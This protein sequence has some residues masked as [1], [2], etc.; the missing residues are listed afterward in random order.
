M[1]SN[2][3]Q[4]AIAVAAV[5]VFAVVLL[6][7]STFFKGLRLDMTE[8]KLFTLSAGSQRI[9]EAIEEPIHLY[10][11]FSEESSRELTQLR[12]YADRVEALL[13][14]YV[15]LSK[16]NL[17]LTQIDPMPFSEAEDQADGFG[18][19]K[20][21]VGS[22]GETLYF[23]LVGSNALDNTEVIGFFQPDRE[24]FLEYEISQLL[25]RLIQIEK[26]K[27]GL[28]SSLPV[29][30]RVNPE[31]FRSE[32]G[33][34]ALNELERNFEIVDIA[35]DAETIASDVTL[36]VMIHPKS[37]PDPLQRSIR[38]FLARQGAVIAFVDPLAEMDQVAPSP[39]MPTLP[40]GQASDLN[41]LTEDWGITL[42]AEQVLADAQLA[43]SVTGQ[44][45]APTRH[46]GILGLG[47]SELNPLEVPTA[48]LESINVASAGLI[49]VFEPKLT[50]TPLLSSS[51]Y[52]GGMD[53]A[54]FQFLRDPSDLNKTFVPGNEAVSIAVLLS[55]LLPASAVLADPTA[56]DDPIGINLVLVS[57]TDILSDRLWVQVQNFFGEPIATAWADNGS[58]LV[59]S[60]EHLAG[61]ADLISIRSRGRYTRPFGVVQDLKREAEAR[62]SQSAALLQVEL[63]ETEQR[64]LELEA[65]KTTDGLLTLSPEQALALEEFQEQKLSIRKQLREVR[66]GLD[67]DIQGLGA[68]LKLMNIGIMPVLL[69]VLLGLY[70]GLR[71]RQI[72][73]LVDEE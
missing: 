40:Q 73:K 17:I 23:G 5:L 6:F 14:E 60:V 1:D 56:G 55:G 31:T 61:G 50:V 16:G 34:Q 41:W 2:L 65:Q 58:F 28:I 8:H 57:D 38:T 10:Y 72:R 35:P 59:N 67:R 64:L 32:P 37:L 25:F 48:S 21:P 66:H 30:D 3:K 18:L 62:Y 29:R 69:T 24:T 11:F 19:Q 12:T 45:G 54:Q 42:R 46:L 51:N 4:V 47:R 39:M 22:A 13:D 43:L 9:I 15:S 70:V 52:A 33:W 36:L 49:D 20:V 26:P 44:N 7:S 71:S 27:I 63:A 53:A 68:N